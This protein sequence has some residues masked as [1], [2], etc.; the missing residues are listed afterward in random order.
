[1]YK[2]GSGWVVYKDVPPSRGVLMAAGAPGR[3]WIRGYQIG[4]FEKGGR[5]RYFVN[6]RSSDVFAVIRGLYYEDGGVLWMGS[7]RLGRWRLPGQTTSV[8]EKMGQGQSYRLHPLESYPN[9]FNARTTIGFEIERSQPL[10]LRIHNTMGQR[11]TTLAQG[12]Y[13]EGMFA[14]LWDGRDARGREVA[15]GVYLCQLRLAGQAQAHSLTLVR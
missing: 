10:S 8:K 5:W 12:V 2:T 3:V 14:V 9:P 7:H 11:V 15:S 1:M 4:V 13:P 6:D